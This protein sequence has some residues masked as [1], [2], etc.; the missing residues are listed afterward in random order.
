MSRLSDVAKATALLRWNIR[1]CRAKIHGMV[2]AEDAEEES[3][4]KGEK[5]EVPLFEMVS[6][7]TVSVADLKVAAVNGTQADVP[8]VD[9]V[10][11]DTMTIGEM[12]KEVTSHFAMLNGKVAPDGDVVGEDTYWASMR[13]PRDE[14]RP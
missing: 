8:I 2:V 12:L 13:K 5:V 7:P 4:M 9:M 3:A 1:R 10:T 14:G 11:G 6:C